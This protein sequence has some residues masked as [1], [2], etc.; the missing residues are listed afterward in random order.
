MG[1]PAVEWR[2]SSTRIRCFT[3]PAPMG[4]GERTITCL[5]AAYRYCIN[6]GSR[7]KARYASIDINGA[8]ILHPQDANSNAAAG[9][10]QLPRWSS[11]AAPKISWGEAS[12]GITL[13]S[14][15]ASCLIWPIRTGWPNRWCFRRNMPDCHPARKRAISITCKPSWMCGWSFGGLGPWTLGASGREG[16]SGAASRDGRPRG[17]PA[18]LGPWAAKTGRASH[19]RAWMRR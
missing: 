3:G 11:S 19:P 5:R 15:P 10:W 7:T 4:A 14:A 2:C 16:L 17:S 6:T 12:S 1:L 9:S 13:P 8:A 18:G